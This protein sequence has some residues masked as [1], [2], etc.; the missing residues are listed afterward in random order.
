MMACLSRRARCARCA[1]RCCCGW[2]PMFLLVGAAAP[3]GVPYWSYAH[4]RLVLDDQMQQLASRASQPGWCS[5]GRRRR[6]RHSGAPTS[7]RPGR[8]TA[9]AGHLLPELH[10]AA[11]GR[12]RASTTWRRATAAGACTRCRLARRPGACRCCKARTSAASSRRARRRGARAHP[13]AAAAVHAGAVGRGRAKLVARC[14]DIGRRRRSRTS[15]TSPNC[16]GARAAGDRAAGGSFN[17]LLARLR[18]AFATQRRFVQ[19]A[20]HE[21]RTPI[22]AIGLQLENVRR[23][24]PAACQQS[25]SQLEAGVRRAQ[26]LVDQLLKLSRQDAPPAPTAGRWTCRRSC[27]RASTR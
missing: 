26:R 1:G 23:E 2:C 4:G 7:C 5:R 20:A 6:A 27:A 8:P 19:D 18:D 17:S 15:T 24:L 21:L 10:R 11:A 14:S 12:R 25:A 13:A 22:T 16:R 3:A 9:A